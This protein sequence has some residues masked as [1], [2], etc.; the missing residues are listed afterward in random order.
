MSR[1][2]DFYF[3][4]FIIYCLVVIFYLFT[5]SPLA[6]YCVCWLLL[7]FPT[8]A[9]S[10][11]LEELKGFFGPIN[12]NAISVL[13]HWAFCDVLLAISTTFTVTAGHNDMQVVVTVT[14]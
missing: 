9:V 1:F 2:F 13:Y 14:K 3:L 4:F 12:V 7:L 8:R 11:S 6:T 10:N 5:V